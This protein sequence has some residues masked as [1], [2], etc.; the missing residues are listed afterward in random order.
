MLILAAWNVPGAHAVHAL[1]SNAVPAVAKY[2]PAVGHS[3]DHRAQDG[4]PV[5]AAY[6]PVGQGV[7]EELVPGFEPLPIVEYEPAGH[8]PHSAVWPTSL[9]VPGPQ[10]VHVAGPNVVAADCL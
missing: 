8:A 6:R 7:H 4:E 9:Q 2:V 5:D 3:E 10:A 1:S